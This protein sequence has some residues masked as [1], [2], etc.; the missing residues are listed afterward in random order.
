MPFID[1]DQ[2]IVDRAGKSIPEIFAEGGESSFR[3]YEAEA[4]RSVETEGAVIATG[5]GI[6]ETMEN[7]SVMKRS[8]TTVYLHTDFASIIERLKEDPNRP[9]WNQDHSKRQALYEKRLPIYKEW[10]DVTI[11][12]NDR[13]IHEIVHQVEPLIK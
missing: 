1:L 2:T 9:L 4:L 12:T 6:I 11:T 13:T 7:R 3:E 10:A 8:G 5:G